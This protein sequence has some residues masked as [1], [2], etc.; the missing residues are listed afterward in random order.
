VESFD[1]GRPATRKVILRLEEKEGVRFAQEK[2]A[3]MH[4]G[5]SSQNE[6]DGGDAWAQNPVRRRF[7]NAGVGRDAKGGGRCRMGMG[8]GENVAQEK[9]VAAVIEV[10]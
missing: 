5:N 4:G 7:S 8:R 3:A 6:A 1:G 2:G 10:L 9:G